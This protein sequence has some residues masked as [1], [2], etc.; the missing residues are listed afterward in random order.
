MPTVDLHANVAVTWLNAVSTEVRH[1][2][3]LMCQYVS[4]Y[5]HERLSY[6]IIRLLDSQQNARSSKGMQPSRLGANAVQH[7]FQQLLVKEELLH[8]HELIRVGILGDIPSGSMF[9]L[10]MYPHNP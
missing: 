2:L 10:H 4:T 7:I 6:R 9:R 3:V 8:V 5:E 1:V